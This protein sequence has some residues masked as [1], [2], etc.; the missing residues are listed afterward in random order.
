[1]REKRV[2][3]VAMGAGF[4][5]MT[6]GATLFAVGWRTKLEWVVETAFGVTLIGW[7][8]L[9][10]SFAFWVVSAFAARYR[11]RIL[12]FLAAQRRRQR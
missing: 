3:L 10:I 1:M 8:L 5:L 12:R 11:M 2:A 7:M 6:V 4:L 9:I